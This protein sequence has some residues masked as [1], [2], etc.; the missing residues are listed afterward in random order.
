MA[1]SHRLF[2]LRTLMER[3]VVPDTDD[4]RPIHGTYRDVDADQKTA[5]AI[6]EWFHRMFTGPDKMP[7]LSFLPGGHIS[8]DPSDYRDLSEAQL[9]FFQRLNNWVYSYARLA[10]MNA[11]SC[12]LRSL[13]DLQAVR[14]CPRFSWCPYNTTNMESL[15]DHIRCHSGIILVCERCYGYADFVTNNVR[16]HLFTCDGT[17]RPPPK[18]DTPVKKSKGRSR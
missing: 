9:M 2:S 5:T 4:R 7:T 3:Y 11:V 14:G 6:L 16:K 17:Y 10:G 12:G 18:R 1:E 13:H 15:S 8:L